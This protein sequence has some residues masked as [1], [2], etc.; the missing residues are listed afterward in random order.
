M[1]GKEG[2]ERYL[3]YS[4]MSIGARRVVLSMLMAEYAELAQR[5]TLE[6][7]QKHPHRI[8]HCFRNLRTLPRK[9]NVQICSIAW[10]R[11]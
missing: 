6:A 1:M 10:K 2:H 7:Q 8:A 5:E 3:S 4:K 9:E 11:G